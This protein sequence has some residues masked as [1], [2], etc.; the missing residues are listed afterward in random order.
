MIDAQEFPG[1]GRLLAIDPGER[2]IGVAVCDEMQLLAKPLTVIVRRSRA[3]DFDRLARVAAEQQVVG[4]VAGHPLNA[5]DSEGSQGRTAARFAHRLAASL[6]LPLVLWDEHGT[7]Q[8]AAERLAHASKR[9]RQSSLDAEA[10]AVLL[11]DFLD[12]RRSQ[13]ARAGSDD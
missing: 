12:T 8:A 1:R 2:R 9:R 7:S 10:A 11:Q 3:E 13:R 6:G 4:L 5:D